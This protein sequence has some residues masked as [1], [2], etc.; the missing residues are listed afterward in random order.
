MWH[1]SD[2]FSIRKVIINSFEIHYLFVCFLV[3]LNHFSRYSL[4]RNEWF[5]FSFVLFCLYYVC[6][7]INTLTGVYVNVDPWAECA[8]KPLCGISNV[9][10]VLLKDHLKFSGGGKAST[11]HKI[12]AASLRATP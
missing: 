1:N 7:C 9:S 5:G 8:R 6:F 4:A 10:A 11:S 12:S 2:L 3:Y